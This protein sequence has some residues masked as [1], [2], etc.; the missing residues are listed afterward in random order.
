MNCRLQ[1]ARRCVAV[2]LVVGLG[3]ALA[4]CSAASRDSGRATTEPLTGAGPTLVVAPSTS[5]GPTDQH[6]SRPSGQAPR[7]VGTSAATSP[8]TVPLGSA[9]EAADTPTSSLSGPT[10]VASSDVVVSDAPA[11]Q[12][13][14]DRAA[15]TDQWMRFWTVAFGLSEKPEAQWGAL[16]SSVSVDPMR[17]SVLES[18]ARRKGANRS[19]YGTIKHSVSLQTPIDGSG[20][21]TVTDCQDHSQAG[22]VDNFTGERSAPGGSRVNVRG[23]LTLGSDDIWRV[24]EYTELVGVPCP[25]L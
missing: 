3:S 6:H 12:E 1:I 21:A 2:A 8:F 4:A 18:A 15:V 20:T 9:R 25:D 23:V 17:A 14:V 13:G 22:I 11:R 19:N 5:N 7:E 10:P 24:R 16:I